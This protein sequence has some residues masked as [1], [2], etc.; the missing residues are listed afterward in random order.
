MNNERQSF[1]KVDTYSAI[2]G[3]LR[4]LSKTN[5]TWGNSKQEVS[6]TIIIQLSLKFLNGL[7]LKMKEK[8]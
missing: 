4:D 8:H 6:G 2:K 1:F 7:F 5:I 3:S